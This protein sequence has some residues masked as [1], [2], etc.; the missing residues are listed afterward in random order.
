MLLL[1]PTRPELQLASS[2][3][4]DSPPPLVQSSSIAVLL[5]LCV[6]PLLSAPGMTALDAVVNTVVVGLVE[7]CSDG[8]EDAAS[9]ELAGDI[10]KRHTHNSKLTC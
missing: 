2:R 8:V 3:P 7:C 1:I 10:S 5:V 9:V 4:G 6:F